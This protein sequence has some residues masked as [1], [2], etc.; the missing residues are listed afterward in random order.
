[1]IN[2]KTIDIKDSSINLRVVDTIDVSKVKNIVAE[3]TE[4]QWDENTSRQ[5]SFKNHSHT[6]TY[7][8]VDYDL[9]WK[10]GEEYCPTILKE[11]SKLWECIKPIVKLLE[12]YHDGSV[13]RVIIP[14]LL[15]GGIIDGHKD[16]GDYLESV[17]RHHIPLITNE[18]V[19][20]T[21]GEDCVNMEEGEIWEINN[22]F[23]HEVENPSQEDRIHLLIDIIPNKYLAN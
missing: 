23:F 12:N 4:Q 3:L 9:G 11:D 1:M 19:F 5:S 14:K 15:P 13:A 17:R 7:F 16:G 20:F 22:N 2:K 21:V 8:L 18:N 10:M 6:K